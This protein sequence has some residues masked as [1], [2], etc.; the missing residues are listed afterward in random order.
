MTLDIHNWSSSAHQELLKIVKD[1]IYPIVNQVDARVQ[2]FKIQFLKEAAKFVRDFKSLANEADESLAK[3][4]ALEFEIERLLR[5]VVSQDIMSIVQNPTVV[6]TSD[7]Q[8][9]LEHMQQKIKRL[10]AHLGDL[11]GNSEDTPCV[12]D[13]IDPLSHKLENENI[14]PKIDKSNALSKPVTS[15]SAHSTRESKVVKNDKVIAPGMFRINPFKTFRE[16]KCMPNKP[17]NASVRT[18]PITVLQPSVIHKQNVN[19]NSN[20]LSSTGL[21]N[22]TKTRMPQPRSNTKNDRVLSVS[23][24]SGMNNKEVE[25]QEHH[26][27]LLLSKNKKHM[28]CECNNIKLDIRNNKSEVVCAMF[29]Q[30]LITSNH[31]VCVLN[32]VNDMNSRV[33]NLNANV[34]NVANQKKHKPKV[35]KPKKERSKEKL[36][37]PKPS[38]PKTCLRWSPIGRKS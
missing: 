31:D 37:S 30:C 1:E 38:R 12:S 4:K 25:V 11:K 2:N 22:T 10:Q 15:K 32:Y 24:S 26:R 35:T 17:T 28:S 6:E 16:E 9:E 8:T 21:E 20:G 13:T 36:A 33:K 14:L 7:L 29:K 3:H 5:A 23:K 19:Y 18:K 34:S 27:N